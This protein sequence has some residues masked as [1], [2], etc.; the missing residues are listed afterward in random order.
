MK[1]TSNSNTFIH[2]LGNYRT[3]ILMSVLLSFF[4]VTLIF[5]PM[6]LKFYFA[7]ETAHCVCGNHRSINSTRC[8]TSYSVHAESYH[9]AT[10][11]DP[12]K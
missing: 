5:E 4:N 7:N 9:V 2:K 10:D 6:R 11:K 3:K 1:H 8:R 12:S